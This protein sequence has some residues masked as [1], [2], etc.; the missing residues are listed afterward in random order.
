MVERSL[1][2]VPKGLPKRRPVALGEE[3]AAGAR[4]AALWA[5]GPGIYAGR[6]EELC[7]SRIGESI[8]CRVLRGLH[9]GAAHPRTQHA[10]E[11]V[12]VSFVAGAAPVEPRQA[13][14]IVW[15]GERHLEQ[16][17]IY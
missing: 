12:I 13:D 8:P 2:L 14:A 16:R 3:H 6:G 9:M 15:E 4:D 7:E 17:E 11:A 10:G 5:R 1:A